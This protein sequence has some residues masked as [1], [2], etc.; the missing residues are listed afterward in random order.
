MMSI[1]SLL[2]VLVLANILTFY[3]QSS[4]YHAG[5]AFLN[6]NFWLLLLI[7]IILFIGAIFAAFPFPLNLPAPIIRAFGSVFVI[8]FVLRV[9]EWIDTV[10]GASLYP[11]LWFLSFIIVP[12]VFLLVLAGGYFRILRRLWLQPRA[13][14]EADG[15]GVHE[16]RPAGER[17]RPVADAKSWE[18][19]GAEFRM[20]LYDI[21]H[22]FRQEIKR[23]S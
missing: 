6:D 13:G 19:I 9:C 16:A 12:V 23:N 8:M 22:R 14:E 11:M 5:V 1:V 4:L 3:I 17:E 15:R 20:M 10:A 18:E 7:A 2:I 21:I